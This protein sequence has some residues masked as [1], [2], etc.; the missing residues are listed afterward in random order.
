MIEPL[1][2]L[3]WRTSLLTVTR[4]RQAPQFLLMHS[5]DT[6]APGNDTTCSV[7]PV[8]NVINISG[9]AVRLLRSDG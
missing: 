8:D 5:A 2:A 6:W 1:A 3:S 7:H 9:L 4:S